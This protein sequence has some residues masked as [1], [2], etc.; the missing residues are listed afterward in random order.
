MVN[1]VLNSI[2]AIST[3]DPIFAF[4]VLIL[5]I[6]I[7]MLKEGL[8]DWKRYKTDRLSNALPTQRLTGKV[9]KTELRRGSLKKQ[10]TEGPQNADSIDR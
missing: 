1:S 4:F 2:P 8:S 6:F 3:N 7:G 9:L 10:T 5:L